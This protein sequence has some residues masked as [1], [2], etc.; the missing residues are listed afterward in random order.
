M[1]LVTLAD[2]RSG[3]SSRWSGQVAIDRVLRAVYGMLEASL[4]GTPTT[5]WRARLRADELDPGKDAVLAEKLRRAVR[6]PGWV[7]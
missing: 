1:G 4:G 7:I 6:A 2:C 5:D 3:G